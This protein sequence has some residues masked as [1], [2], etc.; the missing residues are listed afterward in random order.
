MQ[1]W[2]EDFYDGFITEAAKSRKT[3][4]EKIDAVARGRV[5][6]GEDAINKGL[7][8]QLGGL[9]EAVDAAKK[10][11]GLEGDEDLE[12]SI[13]T[14]GTGTL[15]LLESTHAADKLREISI[16]TGGVYLPPPVKDLAGRLQ[17]LGVEAGGVQ[18]RLEWDIKVE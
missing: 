15:G 8:D 4:K 14:S 2:I 16:D 12:I 5:W 10:R 13:V 7:V 6:A 1:K 3:T 11:A 9:R 18:A 17:R